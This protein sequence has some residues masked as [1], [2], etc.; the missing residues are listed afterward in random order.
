MAMDPTEQLKQILSGGRTSKVLRF[1]LNLLSSTPYVGGIFSAAASAWSETEQDKV[2]RL[3]SV[4]QQLTDDRVT[5]MEGSLALVANSSHLVAASITF[6][7]NTG[8]LLDGFNVSSLTD[9]GTLDFV[10]GFGGD[11]AK[12]VFAC[13]GSGPVSIETIN[14]TSTGMRIVFRSPAPDKVTIAFFEEQPNKPLHPIL[15]SGAA[16]RP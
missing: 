15:G 14:Q 2:N 3:L 8:E 5:E 4:V 7:P 13:Y 11:L 16:R 1:V 10:V 6:N 12:Y 9:C